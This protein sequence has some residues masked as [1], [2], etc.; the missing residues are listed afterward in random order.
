MSSETPKVKNRRQLAIRLE[1][2]QGFSHPRIGL[3][4][5]AL[6]AEAAADLLW[7]VKEENEGLQGRRVL[8]LGCGTGPLALGAALLES[9]FCVGVDLDVDALERAREL[10]R[11]MGV[12][13]RTDWLHGHVPEVGI[14]ADLV[15]QNPPF[16]V[17][18]RGSDKAFL[19]GA[20]SAAPLVYSIHLRSEESRRYLQTFIEKLGARVA[21]IAPITIRL[22]HTLPHHRK[23]LHDVR[24]DVFKITR[25]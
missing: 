24:A 16:G 17:K 8:D 7:R 15:V 14:K 11:E 1:K 3:E 12:E 23:R 20:L 4:Q 6:D 19:E 25:Q 2:I 21:D 5:Y 22:R 9:S 10:S 13:A 18:S